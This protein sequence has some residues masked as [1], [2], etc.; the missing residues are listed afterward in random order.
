MF[1]G[2]P[3]LIWVAEKKTW[4]NEGSQFDTDY[5]TY[6]P[7]SADWSIKICMCICHCHLLFLSLCVVKD[8]HVFLPS[9]LS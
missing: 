8:Y 6:H 2:Q 7:P 5:I 9:S 1:L 4:E 3:S